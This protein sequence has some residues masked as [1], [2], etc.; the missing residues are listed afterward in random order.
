MFLELFPGQ[1]ANVTPEPVASGSGATAISAANLTL[2]TSGDVG[3]TS[4]TVLI[5]IP[6]GN[7]NNLSAANAQL[8][9]G[10]APTDL[11][12]SVYQVFQYI[13]TRP[14][15][16]TSSTP[17]FSDSSQFSTFSPSYVAGQ[18]PIYSYLGGAAPID[19]SQVNFNAT[20]SQG[21]PLWQVQPTA[22]SEQFTTANGT[23]VVQPGNLV[24]D[25]R[26]ALTSAQVVLAETPAFQGYYAYIGAP[27]T[28]DLL[29]T[30]FGD[31]SLWQ[32]MAAGS[33]NATITTSNLPASLLPGALV[34]NLNS[35]V[36]V[37]LQLQT[38][39]GLSISGS[40]AVQSGG[41]V[42]LASPDSLT[43]ASLTAQG[44]VSLEASALQQG[45]AS[46]GSGNAT[47]GDQGLVRV[48]GGRGC[49]HRGGRD[50]LGRGRHGRLRHVCSSW[51]G[52][53][54]AI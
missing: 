6:D 40:L 30:D 9:S 10:A 23:V 51:F 5:A 7:Y 47:Y 52:A 48:A 44:L 29:L 34:T 2:V 19:L 22:N 4:G 32:A 37:S 17:D 18:G 16:T 11:V 8:L 46:A 36:G 53:C 21:Q 49:R 25:T 1:A 27:A 13:G 38:P 33:G 41:G 3:R 24:M 31:A 54:G 15:N 28:L 39:V 50:W 45:S 43:I 26:A 35:V 42:R 14:L 20:N 12:G